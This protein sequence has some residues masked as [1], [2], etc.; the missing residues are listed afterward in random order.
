MAN[1]QVKFSVP[2]LR[3]LENKDLDFV[4]EV[5][6]NGGNFKRLG[7]LRI[8]RGAL[9]WFRGKTHKNGEKMTWEDLDAVMGEH[10]RKRESR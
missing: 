4:V 6:D 10:S 9:V 5:E 7:L 8:S 1:H 2:P 3:S